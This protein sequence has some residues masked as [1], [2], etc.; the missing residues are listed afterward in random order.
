M[1]LGSGSRQLTQLYR[2][3]CLEAT[4]LPPWR[5][6]PPGPRCCQALPTCRRAA[7]P[8]LVVAE[9]LR[10]ALEQ[11]SGSLVLLPAQALGWPPAAS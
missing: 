6:T 11:P 9:A 2:E 1:G 10:A 8:C 3:M 4:F 7:R 5:S